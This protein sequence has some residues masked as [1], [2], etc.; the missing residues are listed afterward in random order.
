MKLCTVDCVAC[1]SLR[2]SLSDMVEMRPLGAARPACEIKA[3]YINSII[4]FLRRHTDQTTLPITILDGSNDAVWSEEGPFW[5]QIAR[6]M[7]HGSYPLNTQTFDPAAKTSRPN[8]F[9]TARD[10]RK[11][12]AAG[13]QKLESGNQMVASFPVPTVL[14]HSAVSEFRPLKNDYNF[15][16]G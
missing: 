5:G 7:F 9:L 2:V 15:A 8:N 14:W 16:K 1:V 11:I 3:F 13:Q 6:K 4:L 10:G 12:S